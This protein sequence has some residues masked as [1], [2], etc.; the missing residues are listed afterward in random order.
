MSVRQRLGA[1]GVAM[2]T[3][4][5]FAAAP[6]HAQPVAPPDATLSLG[7]F[8]E[9]VRLHHPLA[10]QA[11]LAERQVRAEAQAARGA[12]DPYL[13]ATWDIKRFKGIGYYDELDAR[14]VVP[15]PWGVDFK[16]GWERAAG[17]II[18]PERA[19]PGEG[20]L[21]AGFSLPIG[22]R[23]LTDERRTQRRQAELAEA[24]AEAEREGTLV[25]LLQAA[26]RDWGAWYEAELRSTI[27]R[28]GV[29]LARFRYDAMRRRVETGDAAPIDSTEAL[30]ELE[31][32]AVAESE[33]RA[34]ATAARLTVAGYLWRPDG[35]PLAA[36]EVPRP[37][38]PSDADEAFHVGEAAIA[39][40][41]ATHP[42]VQS[43][44]ARWLQADAQRRLVA[45]Q[46]LPSA[47][48][49]V[50]ALAAGRR[51][52]DLPGF[53]SVLDEHK[54]GASIRVPLLAR[55]E[56]GR[57]RAAT[58]RAEALGWERDRVQNEVRLSVERA[59]VDLRAVEEQSARQARVVTA[60]QTLL[61]AELRRFEAGESSLLLVNLRE[62]AVLDE[63]LRQA[64]IAARR[65]AAWGALAAA[66]GTVRVLTGETGE[67]SSR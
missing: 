10:R 2:C 49:D 30:A 53:D 14:V 4:S 52:S 28:D 23:V 26:A 47:S 29:A 41:I 31:R 39:R 51:F 32:R 55:R 22:P 13:S 43:A 16:V 36:T 21:S 8:L 20:L 27:A 7:A 3:V 15:T 33:A 12:F 65:T 18:N 34:S 57:W 58:Q 19:T 48:V 63:R 1:L 60:S 40:A 25:R 17:Q 35:T 61:D 37:A 56:L 50:S 45:L 64:S 42:N 54:A 44:R 11:L 59:L 24:A 66:M 46:V 38:D 6:L 67:S 9:R 5:L 62:R